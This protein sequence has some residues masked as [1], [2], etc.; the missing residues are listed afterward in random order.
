MFLVQDESGTTHEYDDC[1]VFSNEYEVPLDDK[2][3]T[4][5]II[6]NGS[7]Q[8]TAAQQLVAV[9]AQYETP[10][11]ASMKFNGSIVRSNGDVTAVTQEYVAPMKN[12]REKTVGS[13]LQTTDYEVPCDAS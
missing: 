3:S 9:E 10:A 11:D 12:D 6:A 2:P 5:T 13:R 4:A 7:I 1:E 8:D